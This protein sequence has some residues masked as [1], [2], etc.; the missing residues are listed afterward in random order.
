ME[1][2]QKEEEAH[3]DILW[4]L[5]LSC[6]NFSEYFAPS[7]THSSLA[8]KQW[9]QMTN[10]GN[11]RPTHIS[12][13][14]GQYCRVF[15]PSN[16]KLVNINRNQA[17]PGCRIRATPKISRGLIRTRPRI[18]IGPSIQMRLRMKTGPRIRST[19]EKDLGCLCWKLGHDPGS[20]DLHYHFYRAK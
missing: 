3:Q 1:Q 12:P 18:K 2:K 19:Q 7:N 10:S 14:L 15:C 5:L 16:R 6:H 8:Q 13:P 20:V 4:S 9:C 11:H 17:R